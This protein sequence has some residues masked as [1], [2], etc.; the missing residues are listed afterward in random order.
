MMI[1]RLLYNKNIKMIQLL[2]GEKDCRRRYDILVGS[3]GADYFD[4][5][6][7]T[8]VVIDF[9]IIVNDENADNCEV[10]MGS[11]VIMIR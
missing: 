11:E 4:C 5:G 10:I 1:I 7:G 8:D 2:F 3:N 9:N 6:E